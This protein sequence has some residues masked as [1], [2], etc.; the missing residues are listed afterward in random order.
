MYQSKARGRN[1]GK[2]NK[3]LKTTMYLCIKNLRWF[4][5][6]VTYTIYMNNYIFAYQS[7]IIF[8]MNF[9]YSESEFKLTLML[10]SWSY[11]NFNVQG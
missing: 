9:E 3:Y 5:A 2:K 6:G 11:A 8:Q 7:H 4:N 1:H 10:V